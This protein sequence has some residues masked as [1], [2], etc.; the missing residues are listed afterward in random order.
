[1]VRPLIWQ[2]SVQKRASDSVSGVRVGNC[3]GVL[4]AASALLDSICLS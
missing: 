3:R 2:E 1:M 4:A